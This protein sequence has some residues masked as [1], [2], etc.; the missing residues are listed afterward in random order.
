MERHQEKKIG[1]LSAGLDISGGRIPKQKSFHTSFVDYLEEE[2][3]KWR[4]KDSNANISYLRCMWQSLAGLT[5]AP[6]AHPELQIIIDKFIRDV[7]AKRK[8]EDADDCQ[9]VSTEIKPPKPAV[10]IDESDTDEF[11][12]HTSSARKTTASDPL[13]LPDPICPLATSRPLKNL[14]DGFAFGTVLQSQSCLAPTSSVPTPSKKTIAADTAIVSVPIEAAEALQ[15][16]KLRSVLKRYVIWP[17]V[18]FL[19]PHQ[20]ST[21]IT[22]K[23]KQRIRLNGKKRHGEA[24]V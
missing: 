10:V 3:Q 12:D 20:E 13:P 17:E 1:I 15:N 11:F 18:H 21:M 24:A 16:Q 14:Y 4:F 2:A 19:G 9:I 8:H 5:V 6:R 23:R 7:P 22:T